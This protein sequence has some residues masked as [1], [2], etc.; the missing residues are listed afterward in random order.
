M[1]KKLSKY[2]TL[3]IVALTV[4][5]CGGGG[6][7]GT[8]ATKST[9]TITWTNGIYDDWTLSESG[10]TSST[11]SNCTVDIY[12][13]DVWWEKNVNGVPTGE[14]GGLIR[15]DT[16]E[17]NE[18]CTSA[19][20]EVSS[21][22]NTTTS[23]TSTDSDP[24]TTTTSATDVRVSTDDDGNTVTKTYTVYTD[25]T[26]VTTTTTTT[27]TTK[28]TTTYSDGSTKTVVVSEDVS[29]ST[30]DTVTTATREELV[31]TDTTA[32]VVSSSDSNTTTTS[33]S[34]SDATTATTSV[35]EDRVST[36]DD[37]NTVTK[38]YTVYTDTTTTPV[39]TTTTVTTTRTYTWSDGSTT[40]EVVNVATNAST[41][42]SVS[43]S[44]RE[45]L[46]STV[47]TPNVVGT[48]TVYKNESTSTTES[49]LISEFHT[50]N[51]D[52]NAP[53]PDGSGYGMVTTTYFKWYKNTS[54]TT[55]KDKYTRTTYTDGSV[56]D[57]FVETVTTTG[58]PTKTYL[59][60]TFADGS[61]ELKTTAIKTDS[62]VPYVGNPT[63]PTDTTANGSYTHITRNADHN[64]S[65]YDASTYYND[66]AV[67]T[68]TAGV[69]NDPASYKV[70]EAESGSVLPV[71]ANHAYSRGWTGEGSTALIIDT[72]IDQDHAEFTDKIKYTWDAGFAT[73]VEDENGHGTHVAG[74][75]AANKDGTGIHGVAYDAKLAI[76]KIGE[77]N[78]VS[79]SAAKQ[80]LTWAKQY[81]DIVVANLSANTNYSSDYLNAMTNQGNGIYTNSHNIYGGANYYN[82][83]DVST[84]ATA[85]P[86]E[87]VLVVSAGNSNLGYV[88]NPATFASA[89]DDNNNLVLDGRMLIAGNWNVSTQAIDGAKA[90][91]VCKDYTNDTC[92]D[93]YTTSDFYLLAPGSNITSTAN[94]GGYTTMSGTSQAA[95]AITAGVAIVHQLWPYMKG[96]N[97]AQ[98]LLQT[99]NKNLKD[100]DV[101]TH[102]QGLMDLDKATQ[103]VG[104]LGISTTGRTGTTAQVSGSLL[105]DGVDDASVSSV[106]AIDD[107]DR[108]FTVDL[109]S[110]V[111]SNS[112]SVNSY[113]HVVGQSWGMKY[114]N[115]GTRNHGNLTVGTDNDGA[116]AIG[117][118]YEINNNLDL[119]IS[120]S[121]SKTSPWISMS[122]VWGNVKGSSTVDTS[123]TWHNNNKWLQAGLMH[124][125]TDFDKG[126]VVNIDD[127]ISTYLVGG[128]TLDDLVVYAGIAPK[129]LSG[130]IDLRV[131]TSVDSNGI[132]HYNQ[133]TNNYG[134]GTTPFIGASHS[135]YFKETNED[136]S[137]KTDV[138]AD[139]NN[140]VLNTMFVYK[141]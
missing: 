101:T 30:N 34:N 111:S 133:S 76:A 37:G 140:H 77:A 116:Y 107:Y 102:G 75:V 88:Q 78:G 17:R 110:M 87:L 53:L 74:I 63:A 8:I 25:T 103:P 139:T 60:T 73:P 112:T 5:A 81:D 129:V 99:A 24:V 124:T 64:T 36:D 42:N 132:M 49:D 135:Y 109:S 43:T 46:I 32:N 55:T 50:D 86:D 97:I 83:E 3:I 11:N 122:G 38:T 82:L 130:T 56:V 115:V 127:A 62:N 15:T 128:A 89:T 54:T 29:T 67:G 79:L 27:T 70:A 90:G 58:T 120:Y 51:V 131:P 141:F 26:T 134:S 93:T 44:T 59:Y 10:A 104:D 125:K 95:P 71:Y 119:G 13:R 114:A 123:L 19:V 61:Q 57:S 2:I 47:V 105:V 18:Q 106:S 118:D 12:T 72:G 23:S 84:W 40:S 121:K 113:R 9:S 66:V 117:Y 20:T 85:M 22:T 126:L 136:I 35:N 65:T 138:I 92:N 45:E 96:S 21:T 1:I 39:T 68:P 100:Y 48:E 41:A 137:I 52:S 33:T 6:G 108:D 69:D 98:L 31:S 94:G 7:G 91:H 16:E 4:S 14:K 80:A 28:K